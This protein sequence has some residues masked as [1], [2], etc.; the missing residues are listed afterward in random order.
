MTYLRLLFFPV[1]Q[2]LA[3]DY[4]VYDSLLDP[5]VFFSFLLLSSLV[6]LALYLFFRSTG[7]NGARPIS[8]G[9]LW[10]FLALSVESSII[11]IQD[12]INEHRLCLPSIGFF[13]ARSTLTLTGLEW[14]RKRGGNPAWILAGFACAIVLLSTATYEKKGDQEAA[15]RSYQ[16]ALRLQP[17]YPEV[18][19]NLGTLYAR[20]GHH[21]KAIEE[22]QKTLQFGPIFLRPITP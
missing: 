18:H 13:L 3:Y 14:L 15:I 1:N 11:P 7:S 2:N 10:F 9:I 22:Y 20:E 8:F 19:Y 21:E 5:P 17:N 16:I 4:P 12:V 6:S